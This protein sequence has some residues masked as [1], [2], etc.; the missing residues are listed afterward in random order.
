MFA[1]VGE[2]N[3]T[4]SGSGEKQKQAFREGGL[5]FRSI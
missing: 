1:D 5:H 3:V 2:A 4:W